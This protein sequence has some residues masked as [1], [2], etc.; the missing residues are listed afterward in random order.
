MSTCDMLIYMSWCW[1]GLPSCWDFNF[2]T[3]HV[4]CRHH[5]ASFVDSHTVEVIFHCCTGHQARFVSSYDELILYKYGH[6]R[7]CYYYY[8]HCYCWYNYYERI[9]LRCH[10]ILGLQEHFAIKR[11]NLSQTLCRETGETS[12]AEHN[13]QTQYIARKALFWD[14][15]TDWFSSLS[16]QHVIIE[17]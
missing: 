14:M 15:L 8:Y 1:N 5:A 10:K 4:T 17:K 6:L 2:R 9:W 7:Y 16:C 12:R 13:C 11:H 3:W